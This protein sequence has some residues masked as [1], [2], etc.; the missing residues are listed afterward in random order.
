MGLETGTAIADLNE[1]WPLDTDEL[2]QGAA[3]LR[4]IKDILKADVPLVAANVDVSF[5]ATGGYARLGSLLICAGISSGEPAGDATVTFSRAFAIAP[6]V[7][8][9][10]EYFQ[11]LPR[12]LSVRSVSTGSAVVHRVT[13]DGTAS[14]IGF[15]W[16]AV[17]EDG[18]S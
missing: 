18:G 11:P 3:H 13:P 2:N 14:G 1:L 12:V 6:F 10:A 9:T 16:F 15:H 4:L 17:G 8:A 7:M 5:T